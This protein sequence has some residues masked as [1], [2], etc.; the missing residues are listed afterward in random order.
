MLDRDGMGMAGGIA[1]GEESKKPIVIEF[2]RKS[3]LD[4]EP[5]DAKERTAALEKYLDSSRKP[6]IIH[7]KR[8]IMDKIPITDEERTA[9]V[10][11]YLA[12]YKL[13]KSH[14]IDPMGEVNGMY[15][16]TPLIK[17]C[18]EI[19]PNVPVIFEEGV[20]KGVKIRKLTLFNIRRE[21][22]FSYIGHSA[23]VYIDCSEKGI[24]IKAGP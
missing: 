4:K 23:G 9:A 22:V 16:K 12:Y 20:D 2:K 19:F 6:E 7:F 3:L 24:H 17:A 8:G 14:D 10:E 18:N 11:K 13:M 1:S 15:K 5:I 21:N